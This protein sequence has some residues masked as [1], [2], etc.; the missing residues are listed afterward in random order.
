VLGTVCPLS[1]PDP[2]DSLRAVRLPTAVLAVLVA[3]TVLTASPIA[4]A[5]DTILTN[6]RIYTVDDARPHAKVV[7]I[8]G[9]RIVYVGNGKKGAWRRFVGPRTKVVNVRGRPIIP[10]MVDSHTHPPAVTLSSWHVRLPETDNVTTI[11]SFLKQYAADHPVSEAPFIYAEYYPSD[12]DWGPGG[13]TA[14][15]IDAYVSDRPVLLQDF[16]DHA[17]TVNSK[18]LQ[19][20]GVDKNTPLQIDPDDPA[21]Q[22]VRGTDGV[23][24]TGVVLEGA[25]GYFADKMYAAIGW[26]PPSKV[27][28]KLL[29]G[30]TNFLSRKGVAALFDAIGD[31]DAFASAA[32]LDRQGK[33][34]LNYYGSNLFTSLR[35]L[36]KRIAELRA[37]QRKYG[38]KHVKVDTMKLFLDGTNE[39]GTSAVLEPFAIGD[40]DQG[41]LRVSKR[42]L[43]AVMRK[44]NAEDLDL[45]IH[46]VG[47]RAFRTALDAVETNKARLGRAWRM[48]VTLCHDEL[49]DPADMPRV[50]KL[51]VILNWTPHWSGGYFG[52]AAADWLGWNRFNRMY[53]FNPIIKSGGIVNYGSDVV[54]EYEAARADPFFGM[55]VGHTRIDPEYP[56]EPGR[57]TVPGT[58]IRKPLSARLS[59]KDLLEGYT[60]NGAI[61]LRLAK[62]MGSIEV[63]KLA[64]LSILN[65]DLFKVPDDKIQD[66]EPEA[67]M[68]EGKVVHGRL[69]RK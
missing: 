43:T 49:V 53:Q 5:A 6:A 33:L 24:P 48:R 64:N 47:D 50:A 54:T 18:M 7:A 58:Q 36:P 62:R 57:G 23:T 55:Q 20:M 37:W 59:L 63:G 29:Y 44:L 13:Q 45:H 34:N 10:G 42:D 60:R 41:E 19:L 22:F 66:V 27:T 9:K 12:M 25:W 15:A 32:A 21:V 4:H 17:S 16:S 2:G 52:E 40:D 65:A 11:L 3:V 26:S 68:F 56:M 39:I 28:P 30:F 35:D 51:G 46:L 1:Q 38:G 31:K 67:V 69:T 14:A 8:S 61:Q